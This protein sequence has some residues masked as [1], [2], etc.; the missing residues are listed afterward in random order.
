MVAEHT[1][2]CIGMAFTPIADLMKMHR[3]SAACVYIRLAVANGVVKLSFP[4]QKCCP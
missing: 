3:R 4:Q 2:Y 1:S